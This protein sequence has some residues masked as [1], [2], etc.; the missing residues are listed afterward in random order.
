[1]D[2][3]IDKENTLIPPLLLQPFVE[4]SII[5]GIHTKEDGLIKISITKEE[6]MI[7][8][9]VEDNG[10]GRKEPVKIQS[11][12][13]K[14]QESLGMKITQERLHI[15]SRLKKVKTAIHFFDLEGVE[16]ATGGLRIELLLPF[17]QVF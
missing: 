11:G 2:P 6:N 8:C 16:H 13:A 5:H 3:Q 4:N 7:R 15:I 9:I 12:G 17:E 14:K 10:I 1:V